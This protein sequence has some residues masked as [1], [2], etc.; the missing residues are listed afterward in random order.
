MKID[1][2]DLKAYGHFTGQ[3]LDFRGSARLHIICGPNEA[4]KT[5]LW[6]AINGAL[7]G[8]P[9]Q[10]RDGHLHGKPKLRVGVV[11][12]SAAGEQLAVMR[13]KGRVNTLLAYNPT[14]GDE[15]SEAVPEERLRE[16]L[17]GLSQGLFLAMFSL[18]H[19]ALV[20]GGEALAQGKGDAGESLFEAG[21]GLGSIRAL[22]ARL[23][24]EA[25]ILFKPRAST[26]VIYRTL[27]QYEASRK[28]ARDAAVRPA[29]WS[30]RKAALATADSEYAA[31]RAEQASLLK[32][33]RR[34][35]RL[36][37]ILPDVAALELAQQRLAE[38]ADVPMLPPSAPAERVAAVT[39]QNAGVEAE[40]MASQ[41][42]RQHQAEL[43]AI[44]INDAVLA[45][46]ESVEAL[47][48]ATGTYR[49]ASMQLA[50]AAF[51]IERARGEFAAIVR[52]IAGE[53][54]PEQP[55]QWLPDPTGVARIRALITAGAMLKATHRACLKTFGEKQFELQQLDAEILGLGS[56][57]CSGDLG[58]YLDS[59]ADH[60][61]PE[62]GAQQLEDEATAAEVQLN[63][64][65]GVLKMAS[66]EAVARTTIPL[67]AEVQSLKSEDEELRRRTRSIREA[68]EKIENDLAALRGE[69]KGLEIRG[70]VPTKT[71]LALEREKRD[72]LWLGIRR[73][74]M[75]LAGESLAA[76]PPPSSEPYEHAVTRADT[77][78]DGLFADAERV[79]RYAEFRVRETQM[80]SALDLEKGRAAS[81]GKD[82]E[83]LERRW[84]ELI[85]VHGWPPLKLS[86]GA[87][88]IARREAF[89]QRRNA[90]QATRQEAEQRRRRA[91]EIRSRLGEIYGLMKR[92][93]PAPGERL[94][95][96][97]A[98]A[99]AI[100]RHHADHLTQRQLK[101]TARAKAAAAVQHAGAAE[102]AS[103]RQLDEWKKQ[104]GEAMLAIRLTSEA[105]EE[106]ADARL[107][108]LSA[109]AL[110]RAALD[111][112]ENEQRNAGIQ[113]DDYET[114]LTRTWLRVR[115]QPIPEDGRTHDVLAGELYRELG[116]ARLQ[117]DRKNTLTQQL[118]D[119]QQAVAAARQSAQ[120]A[121]LIIDRLL[122][123]ADCRTLEDLELV[124]GE[125]AL[126][127]ALVT[128]VREI[129]ARLV[130][131]AGL[132]L[133]EALK[134]AVGQD[135]DAIAEA[136][137]HNMHEQE[138]SAATVQHHHEV[139]LAARQA[140]EKMGGSAVAADA[141]QKAAQYAARISELGAD[142]AATRIA[143]AVIAQV[144]D[145]YQKRN[146]GPLVEQASRRFAVITAGRYR[147]VVVD[148]DDER[149][150][151]KAVRADGERLT[152]EQLSTG[153]RD[154]LFLA[155][156]LAA[157]EGHLENGEPLPVIVDDI[158]IQF[159]DEA[160]AAT[161][162][163]LADLSRRT[164]VLFLTHHEHLLD[165]ARAA[166]G[167]DA[168][169]VQRLS[170]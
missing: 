106:E 159:D 31:A 10:T 58:A 104:W 46:A 89:L 99:R 18:D 112:A 21:A 161:F 70:E 30:S 145:A 82:R 143:S 20:R 92:P 48:H 88:W 100:A 105:S 32:D 8:V 149:Q 124:E 83:D 128:E 34:L 42:W 115:H 60:G 140:F 122:Q 110:A 141:Q 125:S 146:Q 76:E 44:E 9:E 72:L 151:L 50:K 54:W 69:I 13:R 150:I 133:A 147:G 154:Q 56:E 52:Q 107:E 28:Q 78:A 97:L 25:E 111:Q 51:G 37:A 114:R 62:A 80:Q 130:K 94:S 123:Q 2:L 153:R 39:K 75:P 108:Q 139:F 1:Q 148:Y 59:I 98:R 164:Q 160:A 35:E 5:T 87:P 77:T 81:V 79:T 64:E 168:Y 162:Q 142:Y 40:R 152:M 137:D 36:A 132:P 127:A 117:Q 19:E 166:I 165:V 136:L 116:A 49:E 71:A 65:A 120:D 156:R 66:A 61:D 7:F 45:D 157:I 53:Q 138:R 33:A 68:M 14:S 109:L 27:S 118:A 84:G 23:D 86:E 15:L 131:S 57:A 26:S 96:T 22:R 144:I 85:G 43:E 17:G 113:I 101:T 126:R 74:F 119:A 170:P 167:D 158:L 73:H 135:P 67:E 102:I 47:Q 16:W 11:L 29:E 41:R 134:Q 4:G 24:R 163:V 63:S 103:R 93:V 55:L 129:E 90:W 3:R 95:E 12:T 121:A 38:R 6:R 91:R 169:R 155:L